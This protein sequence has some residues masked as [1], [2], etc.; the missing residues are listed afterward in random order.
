MDV[1]ALRS[2]LR[3]PAAPPRPRLSPLA[4]MACLAL[5]I[6]AN[7]AIFS[8]INAVL[9]RPLPY[10][11]ARPAG[12]GLGGQ[13]SASHATATPSR[14]R[15]SS[16]GGRR[17]ACSSGIGRPS[18]TPG[19][20]PHRARRAGCRC[21]SST[22]R[23]ISSGCWGCTP[24]WAGPIPPTKI[25]RAAPVVVLSYGLW[26]RRFGGAR[27]VV[28]QTVELDGAAATRSSGV[29]PAG[30]GLVGSARDRRTLWFRSPSIRRRITAP[31]ADATSPPWPASSP[32]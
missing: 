11:R 24:S 5:G 18:T 2:A 31:S 16:I 12:D 25:A 29:L 9:L 23:R 6:G 8:V 26:Q 1:T 28:G 7:T 19:V 10:P 22:R 14:P 20:E 15:T 27:D 17:A 32:A 30:A 21:R 3:P 13:R 4:A